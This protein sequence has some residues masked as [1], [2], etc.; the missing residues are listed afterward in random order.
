[1]KAGR[2][3]ELADLID[4]DVLQAFAVVGEP[5][6]LPAMLTKRY[7]GIVDRLSFYPP[8]LDGVGLL[9]PLVAELQ[10]IPTVLGTADA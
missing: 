5:G 10:A 1:M 6:E 7:A 2:W 9:G 4:D 3:T 8:E